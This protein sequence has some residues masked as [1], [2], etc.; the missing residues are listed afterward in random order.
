MLPMKK[1]ILSKYVDWGAFEE[2]SK[3][4]RI[5]TI[6]FAVSC[7]FLYKFMI[8]SKHPPFVVGLISVFVGISLFNVVGQVFISLFVSTVFSSLSPFGFHDLVFFAVQWL[9]CFITSYIISQLVRMHIREYK[10]TENFIKT[11]VG[12][13]ESRDNYTAYHSTNVA[14]YALEIAMR[15]NYSKKEC[16]IIFTGA[17]LHDI[18]KI[19]ISDSILNKP[20]KLTEKEY[21]HIKE[22]PLMGYNMLNNSE[23][24]QNKKILDMILYHHERYDGKGYPN[25]LKGDEI[26]KC[27]AIV[28]VADAFDAMIS[29]RVYHAE[30]NLDYAVNE[31]R[32]NAGTQFDP[33]I[34]SIFLEY[35]SDNSKII[36]ENRKNYLEK[37]CSNLIET[38]RASYSYIFNSRHGEYGSSVS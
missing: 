1:Y 24:F 9:S 26:P 37:Y 12:T 36:N 38:K 7:A 8:T 27:A 2:N 16:N 32:K 13:I 4:F 25:K 34:S 35:I 15:L 11:L 28:A 5:L 19:G 30:Y 20:S 3:K 17:L 31:I 33:K 21:N 6:L 14:K 18:G 23:L 10:S 22:H 29:K